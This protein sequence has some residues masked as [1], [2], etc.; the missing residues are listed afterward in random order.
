MHP[1]HD[2]IARQLA[3]K[4]KATPDGDGTLLDHSLIMY[5]SNMGNSNQHMHFGH[6]GRRITPQH[7]RPHAG[8]DEQTQLRVRS[9][10]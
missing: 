4:L 10:L 6:L 9:A 7:Q 2:Y 1:L 3:E 5:G 8:I